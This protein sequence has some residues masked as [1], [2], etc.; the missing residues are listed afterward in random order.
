MPPKSPTPRDLSKGVI[1]VLSGG[2]VDGTNPREVRDRMNQ[3][4][5][6]VNDDPFVRAGTKGKGLTFHLLPGQKEK[7]LHQTQWRKVCKA[8]KLL[9][10][11]PLILVG[12]SN[13][14]AAALNIVRCLQEKKKTVD[15]LFT[16][17]SVG[18]LDDLGHPHD[19]NRVPGNVGLNINTW[20]IPTLE[21]LLIP[22]PIGRP[23][24]RAA[25]NSLNSLLNVGMRY[26]LPGAIAH[27]NAFYH[28]AGGDRKYGAPAPAC[29]ASPRR[30]RRTASVGPAGGAR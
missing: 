3:Y 26:R 7:Y 30:D 9:E 17:D 24:V 11:S 19:V 8:L 14:G 18:T 22:F 28:P 25:D 13:G 27:R 5:T 21:N 20:V 23:N 16:A 12:H 15:F 1:V 6:A 4:I 10:A 2:P 29:P